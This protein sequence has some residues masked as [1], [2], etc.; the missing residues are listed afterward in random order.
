MLVSSREG[1][2]W[3]YYDKGYWHRDL[4]D[5]GIPK[6]PRQSATS[7]TP[8]SGDHWGAGGA[9]AGKFGDDPFAYIPSLQPFHGIAQCAYTKTGRGMQG[10]SWTR[11]VLDEYGTPTQLLKT[12]DGPGHFVAAGDFD[13]ELPCGME[14][15]N[16]LTQ[17]AR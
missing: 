4:I 17:G 11:H 15:R 5:G 6:E 10:A 13:G 7:E 9:D 2:T 8:G 12:G 16:S 3:L 1:T 14:R